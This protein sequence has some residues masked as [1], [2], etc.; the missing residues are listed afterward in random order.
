M[1]GTELNETKKATFLL[2]RAVLTA[3]DEFVAAG[4]APSKNALVERALRHE[5]KALRRERRCQLL[6]AAANDPLFLQ[7]IAE[8]QRDFEFADAET[9]QLIE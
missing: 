1:R 2:S 4:A 7:D 6:Q 5:L 8:V 9:A 3:M